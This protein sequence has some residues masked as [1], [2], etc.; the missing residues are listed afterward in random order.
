MDSEVLRWMVEHRVPWLTDVFWVITTIGNTFAMSVLAT[1]TTVALALKG[2][3]TDAVMV[4]V[5]MLTGYALMN[6]LKLYFSRDRPLIP[7]RLVEITS[8]SFPSGHAM[9]SAILATTVTALM[10]RS[11]VS[12]LRNPVVL[13]L[14]AVA[15]LLIGF[16]RI[17]LGAHWTTDVLAG[18]LFGVIWGAAAVAVSAR[19]RFAER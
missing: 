3:R 1:I 11:T 16:S 12:W 5:S 7:D 13:A 19:S 17:Y 8:H 10:W 2:R 18:W 6:L 9:M 15:S 14:P 4:A